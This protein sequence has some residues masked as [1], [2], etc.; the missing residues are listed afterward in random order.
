MTKRKGH[1]FFSLFIRGLAMGAAEV[2]PGV[3]GGTIALLTGVYERL[4]E[5]I[6][7]IGSPAL[8]EIFRKGGLPRF[9]KAIDGNFLVALLLGMGAAILLFSRVITLL[10]ESYPVHVWAAFFGLIV[11]SIWMVGRGVRWSLAAGAMAAAGIASGFIISTAGTG[12]LPAGGLGLAIGGGLSICAMIL[13]GISGSFVLL[14]LD[15]YHEIMGAVATLRLPVLLPFALGAMV[16]ILC[17]SHLLAWLL[18]RYHNC[19]IALLT[20]FMAGAMV[21]VWPWREATGGE[22]G[23]DSA[24]SPV[25]YAARHGDAHVAAAVIIAT[26]ACV[27]VLALGHLEHRNK[28]RQA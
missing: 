3:S 12:S 6:R 5:S 23:I 2:V 27:L 28:R 20:G 24:V 25:L 15:R 17:F 4:I 9:W 10:L 19:T 26:L 7:T 16:G 11:A 13:P 1:P 21:K 18:K 22:A 14:L 8:K